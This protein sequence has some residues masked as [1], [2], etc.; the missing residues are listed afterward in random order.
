MRSAVADAAGLAW[1]A[2]VLLAL[3]TCKPPA[4][5]LPAINSAREL[6]VPT[7]VLKKAERFDRVTVPVKTSG[8]GLV[9]TGATALKPKP[10][11]GCSERRL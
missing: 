4:V 9:S 7:G 2:K 11:V 10:S 3:P 8:R 6:E 5:L 1:T